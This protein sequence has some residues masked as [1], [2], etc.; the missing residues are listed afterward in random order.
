MSCEERLRKLRFPALRFKRLRGDMIETYKILTGKYNKSMTEFMP[1]QNSSSTSLPARGHIL[2][3]YRQRSEKGL[4]QNFFT[5][6]V[7]NQWN[8]LPLKVIESDTLHIFERRL[9]KTWKENEM[10]YNVKGDCSPATNRHP[11]INIDD[12]HIDS[13]T[14]EGLDIY[15]P[16]P[17][18]LLR[19]FRSVYTRLV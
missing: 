14:V 12:T 18:I 16:P 17:P 3:L 5:V 15:R 11:K 1:M 13:R 7:A 6:Q 2:K 19:Q 4:R 9:D 10:K 8:K